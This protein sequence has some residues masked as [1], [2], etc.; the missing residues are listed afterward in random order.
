MKYEIS[1]R[2]QPFFRTA[3]YSFM[4][5]CV[6]VIVAL[7][8]L[9]VMGYSFDEKAGRL[10]QGGLLQFASVPQGATVTLDETRLS[11]RTNTKSTVAAG[12]HSVSFDRSGY[13]SWR[14]TIMIEPAQIGWLNYARLIP[15]N[16]KT[17][18]LRTF[19]ELGGSLA[20]PQRNYMLLQQSISKPEF[21]LVNIQGDTVRYDD[22]A[23]PSS[24]YKAPTLASGQ[25]FI[26]ENWSFDEQ[27]I[28]IRHNYDNGKVEWLLLDRS[29][30][31]KSINI[32]TLFN[33]DVT[34]IQF[35]GR[36]NKLLFAQVADTVHRISLDERTIS[37]PLATRV[38]TFQVHDEKT[39][40]YTSTPDDKALR[41]V[42][43]A[44]VD[45]A[46]PYIL[47]NFPN[48]GQPLLISIG[49]YFNRYYVAILHGTE[50]SITRGNSLPLAG[51]T[52]T[53]KLF[54]KQAVPAGATR[55]M[56]S[57]KGR[58]VVL[59]L[60]DGYATYDLELKKYD[61]TTWAIQPTA[62]RGL[63]WLDDYMLWS[64]G[65]DKLRF[66]EFDGANQQ[67]IM[68]VAEGYSASV[69]P[70]DKYVYA[71]GRID[72]KLVFKRGLLILQ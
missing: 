2:R 34:K 65:G 60:A 39:I 32:S 17:E 47:A 21:V 40:A 33:I 10:E 68:D 72:N 46:E 22:L 44:S 29:S 48:D 71:I 3:V 67:N 13:R 19:Q 6:I 43:Y 31:E 8:T 23:L 45:M 58:F 55:L 24:V 26:L 64:D 69:S 53:L 63:K 20:S 25:E 15:Q 4:T 49:Q 9:V 57:D 41:H 51:S 7:L 56:I 61:K 54:I 62:Q 42:G 1:K 70:N 36:G 30:P 18:S 37:K 27:A 38:D 35:A 16:I 50:L 66:Y 5:L 12:S 14:K 28:V 52:T 11:S 59:Q